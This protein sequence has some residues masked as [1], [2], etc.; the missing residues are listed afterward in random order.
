MPIEAHQ[1]QSRDKAI[2]WRA[3]VFR[4]SAASSDDDTLEKSY[5]ALRLCLRCMSSYNKH[6]TVYRVL[7]FIRV[8]II[9]TLSAIALYPSYES[10]TDIGQTLR[11]LLLF[12]FLWIFNKTLNYMAAS[13]S[14]NIVLHPPRYEEQMAQTVKEARFFHESLRQSSRSRHFCLTAEELMGCIPLTAQEGDSLALI[15]RVQKPLVLRP[16]ENG[17]VL[18]EPPAFWDTRITKF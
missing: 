6:R 3:L 11:I 16:E 5:R 2:S 13:I 14:S 12:F 4:D 1:R 7:F 17:F 10:R 18:V 9:F 15:S 8:C